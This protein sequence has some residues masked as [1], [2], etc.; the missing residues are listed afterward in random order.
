MVAQV[1][2]DGSYA[3]TLEYSVQQTSVPPMAYMILLTTDVGKPS[4]GVGIFVLVVQVSPNAKAWPVK[5]TTA[6]PKRPAKIL[7]VMLF[8]LF[9]SHPFLPTWAKVRS[10]G[11][12][13]FFIGRWPRFLGGPCDS[14]QTPR[15][16]H[17]YRVLKYFPPISRVA[18]CPNKSL[19]PHAV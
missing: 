10:K 19:R 8:A 6:K 2:V 18:P 3:S 9:I 7:R 15:Y 14:D 13:Y 5:I 16:H 1:F 17:F 11:S 4:R 12:E